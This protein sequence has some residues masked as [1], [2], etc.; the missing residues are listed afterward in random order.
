[1]YCVCCYGHARVIM[2]RF[3]VAPRMA[4]PR[5]PHA[6]VLVQ[7]AYAEYTVL[8]YP[9]TWYIFIGE[10]MPKS[11]SPIVTSHPT[12]NKIPSR[13]CTCTWYAYKVGGT[14]KCG[15]QV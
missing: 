15:V 11:S 4:L 14:K 5:V 10:M 2:G 7:G 3:E 12:S 13:D 1:M 8:E 6:G 9:G